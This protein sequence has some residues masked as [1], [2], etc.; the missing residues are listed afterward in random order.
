MKNRKRE[1]L[2]TGE[3][4]LRKRAKNLVRKNQALMSVLIFHLMRKMRTGILTYYLRSVGVFSL[5]LRLIL[6]ACV[7]VRYEFSHQ[8]GIFD[9]VHHFDP[10]WC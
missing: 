10:F 8:P 3:D 4:E 9:P 1:T 6:N 2:R 5:L 7:S